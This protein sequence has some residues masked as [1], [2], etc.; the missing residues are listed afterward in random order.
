MISFRKLLYE[1][2]NKKSLRD[3]AYE[4][5]EYTGLRKKYLGAH[6]TYTGNFKD[7]G[8]YQISLDYRGSQNDLNIQASP[9]PYKAG[10]ESVEI[11]F[12]SSSSY[13]MSYGEDKKEKSY[14]SPSSF[15]DDVTSF[16]DE[17]FN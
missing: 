2:E 16:V 4:I 8:E 6:I 15:W 13:T 7:E 9:H 10:S 12:K 14:S 17:K 3:V 1:D 11:E 5:G